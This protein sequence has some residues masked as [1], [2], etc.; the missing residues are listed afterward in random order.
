MLQITRIAGNGAGEASHLAVEGLSSSEI[1]TAMKNG[2]GNLELIGFY[3]K[4]GVLSRGATATAGSVGEVALALLGRTAVTAVRSGSNNLLLISWAVSSG[5]QSITRLRDS[6]HGAGEASSIAIAAISQT[7]FVTALRDGS[8]ELLL[9]SW[10]LQPDGSFHRLGDSNPAGHPKQAGAVSLVAA[11]A[12]GNNLVVTAVKNGSR[13][14]ELIAWQVSSDGS[15][16]KRQD[17]TGTTAGVVGQ[18][19]L[20]QI[21]G[22]STGELAITAYLDSTT[23]TP[24]VITAMQNASGNL[25][26]IAWRIVDEGAGFEMAADTNTMQPASDRPGTASHISIGPS[27][28]AQNNFLASMRRGSGDLELIDFSLSRSG[29]KRECSY[30]ESQGTD[31]TETALAS[32]F[33]RAVS[34]TRKADFLNVFLWQIE[35]ASQMR[36]VDTSRINQ[37][38]T[39][40]LADS[41][42]AKNL[43]TDWKTLLENQLPLTAQQK[44]S[45][46]SI[47]ENDAKELN[48]AVA[49]VVD[50]GG[51]IHLERD[52]ERSAGTLVVQ[53]ISNGNKTAD[54]SVGVFHCKFDANCRNWH[55]GWGPA[56]K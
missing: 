35:T 7:M 34:V 55:C 13:E 11:T 14:L 23:G 16:I 41:A 25:Q 22:D 24:G 39:S 40:V 49:M 44:G 51:T 54:L 6:G 36:V 3:L 30:G 50:H 42:Q 2:S 52:S 27:G 17:P 28:Y 21:F 43:K 12:V 5:L 31:V 9:I 48:S 53:P 47:P 1:L 56:R 10:G 37:W 15:K 8:G 26:L 18:L 20:G 29:W 33:G 46:A 19:G 32:F 45:I 38:F 4:E